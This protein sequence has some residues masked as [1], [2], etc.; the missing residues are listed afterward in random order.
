MKINLK[1]PKMFNRYGKKREGRVWKASV[2]FF[3]NPRGFLVH[4]VKHA[5]TIDT[6]WGGITHVAHYWCG[7]HGSGTS[8]ERWIEIPGTS[9]IVCARCEANAVAS[10]NPTSEDLVGRHVH[11]GSLKIKCHCH[12]ELSREVL[13]L[14]F[15]QEDPSGSVKKSP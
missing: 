1:P 2:P 8:P 4:R 3:F 11:I 5:E 7:N 6:S 15:P 12:P 9:A 10:G 13:D 14:P